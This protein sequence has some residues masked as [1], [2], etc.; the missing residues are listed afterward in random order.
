MGALLW[1]SRAVNKKLSVA[2]SAICS[3]QASSTEDIN[4]AIHQL[5]DYCAT[6]P[7]Y[8]IL[9]RSSDMILSG[10]SDAGFN[11]KTMELNRADA[12]I[13]L[14]ENESIPRWNGP[15][16]TIAQIMKYFVSLSAE[17]ELTALFF[18]GKGDDATLSH[19]NQNGLETAIF[20][21]PVRQ[22][23]FCWCGQ[24]YINSVQVKMV[25]FTPQLV[26]LQRGSGT[27]PYLLG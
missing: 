5:L 6:Y 4:K 22:F 25:G 12:H 23:Y 9:Y 27:V 26:T 7:D 24:L 15:I 2:L 18:N 19:A 11:N 21:T 17:A 13:F 16:L 3:Q 20:T 1:I 8:G 10:H 14:S